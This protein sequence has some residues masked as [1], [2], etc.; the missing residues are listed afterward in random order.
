MPTKKPSKSTPARRWALIKH[1]P[2]TFTLK[3]DGPLRILQLSDLHWDNK[4]C[5][6]DALKRDLDEAVAENAPILLIGDTFCAMQGKWDKRKDDRQLRP[7]HRGGNYLDKLV[8]T[9]AEWFAP[10]APYIALISQGNHETS[11]MAHHQTDLLQRL[12][13]EL[14]HVKGYTGELGAY[15][16]FIKVS[17]PVMGSK[18]SRAAKVICW[19][20]GNG[21]GGEV[22]R[23]MI[24]NNRARGMAF[25]DIYIGGHIHR[26]NLD[27]NVILDLDERKMTIR[28]RTQWFLRS[29]TYKRESGAHDGD[30]S[31][32]HVERRGA[33]ERPL[34]GWWLEFHPERCYA[35]GKAS[36]DLR[37]RPTPTWA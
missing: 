3:I 23:G 30:M 12:H 18:T 4:H 31:G 35:A 37:F 36:N 17:A 16:G 9:A 10:Y 11:I 5:D 26:R 29:S 32:F 20:H 24:D 1:K 34:G 14:K 21:G 25:A 6:R 19:N 33:G 13:Q 22:T 15:A 2:S 8:E 27:E 7:E 28:Q